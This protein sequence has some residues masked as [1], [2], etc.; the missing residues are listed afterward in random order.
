MRVTSG[1]RLF[2]IRE[3]SDGEPSHLALPQE[4]PQTSVGTS[5]EDSP[6]SQAGPITLRLYSVAGQE[7]AMLVNQVLAPG[8]YSI[9]LDASGFPAGAYFCTLQSGAR[10][11]VRRCFSSSEAYNTSRKGPREIVRGPLLFHPLNCHEGLVVGVFHH[12]VMDLNI[13]KNQLADLLGGSVAELL[14]FV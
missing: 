12:P 9:R 10:I 6:Q 1:D 7:L 8:L 14:Q 4:S 5:V 13:L 2:S 3:N 11:A